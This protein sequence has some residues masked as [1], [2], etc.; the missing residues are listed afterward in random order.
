MCSFA[1]RRNAS[2]LPPLLLLLPA[3]EI[4]IFNRC[5]HSTRLRRFSFRFPVL[6]EFI[7]WRSRMFRSFS[8]SSTSLLPHVACVRVYGQ[9][10]ARSLGVGSTNDRFHSSSAKLTCYKMI[11]LLWQNTDFLLYESQSPRHNLF[12][13]RPIADPSPIPKHQGRLAATR[14][15]RPQHVF[16]VQTIDIVITKIAT[17]FNSHLPSIVDRRRCRIRFVHL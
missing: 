11:T 17:R 5:A 7:L 8:V 13:R 15:P 6:A 9:V 16:V 1:V 3:S 2:Q 4:L 10:C 14:L 12:L